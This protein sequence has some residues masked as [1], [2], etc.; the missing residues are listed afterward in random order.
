MAEKKC[1]VC[2]SKLNEKS[3]VVAG[4]L[5]LF[6]GPKAVTKKQNFTLDFSDITGSKACVLR[7]IKEALDQTDLPETC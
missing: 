5:R 4:T 7:K 6:Y 3:V 1:A 2:R